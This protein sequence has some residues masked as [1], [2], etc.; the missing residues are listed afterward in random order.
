MQTVQTTEELPQVQFLDKDVDIHAAGEAR[1][2]VKLLGADAPSRST[3]ICPIRQE[4][5]DRTL[6]SIGDSHGPSQGQIRGVGGQS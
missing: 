5:A 3:L 2:N 1:T 6:R 4:D